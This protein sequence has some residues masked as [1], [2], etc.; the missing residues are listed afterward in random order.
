LFVFPTAGHD[1]LASFVDVA[2]QQPQLP[3][4]SQKDDKSMIGQTNSAQPMHS[5]GQPPPPSHHDIRFRDHM[6]Q[7]QYRHHAV[8]N[9]AAIDLQRRI[10]QNK[11]GDLRAHPIDSRDSREIQKRQERDRIERINQEQRLH[12]ERDR[13]R[14]AAQQREH[15]RAIDE[16][17]RDGRRIDRIYAINSSNRNQHYMRATPPESGPPRAIPD[18]ERDA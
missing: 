12:D 1:A 8:A 4:P 5:S 15:E 10:D 3:V 14:T 7:H 6:Q 18:R 11:R 2:V 17:D 13:Q 9:A 16:R